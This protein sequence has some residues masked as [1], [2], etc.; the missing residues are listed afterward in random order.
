VGWSLVLCRRP[1]E[2]LSYLEQAVALASDAPRYRYH[3]AK[4]YAGLDRYAEARDQY[5]RVMDLDPGGPW[6]LLAKS[7]LARR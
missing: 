1:A 3:L 2:A 4:A 7:E 5:T 6:E